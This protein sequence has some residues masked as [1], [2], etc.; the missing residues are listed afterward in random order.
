MEV[1][2][3][4]TAVECIDD[5]AVENSTSIGCSLCCWYWL[6]AAGAKAIDA[7][8]LIVMQYG[9]L[10]VGVLLCELKHVLVFLIPKALFFC[11]FAC[12]CSDM[13]C[14]AWSCKMLFAGCRSAA[15]DDFAD[16]VADAPATKHCT[17]AQPNN[18]A[19][20]IP[21]LTRQSTYK[22]KNNQLQPIQCSKGHTNLL[23]T[24]TGTLQLLE[25]AAQPIRE[26]QLTINAEW[27]QIARQHSTI[28]F[29]SKN[30]QQ[31]LQHTTFH[32]KDLQ[33]S[34]R[35]SAV[36]QPAPVDEAQ[37]IGP[38]PDIAS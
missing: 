1:P 32:Q 6:Y 28:H 33:I 21:G 12:C 3:A 10:N 24:S 5:L 23:I 26:Q 20:G 27:E 4:S 35:P 14:V 15:T 16:S 7:A 2:H 13:G 36:I 38:S 34:E 9:M 22:A 11:W 19:P 30:Q 29:R 37:Q 17:R 8:R 18:P 25:G 31:K